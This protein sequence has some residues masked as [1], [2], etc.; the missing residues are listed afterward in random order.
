MLKRYILKIQLRLNSVLNGRMRWLYY[1]HI[2]LRASH[3]ASPAAKDGISV[4][5]LQERP[6]IDW[7]IE[8]YRKNGELD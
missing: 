4:Q 6:Q 8:T 5:F 3:M 2:R 1:L 7:Q